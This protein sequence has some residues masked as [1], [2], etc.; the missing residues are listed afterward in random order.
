MGRFNNL[1]DGYENHVLHG[2]STVGD[3]TFTVNARINPDGDVYLW[4]SFPQVGYFNLTREEAIKLAAI[5][6]KRFP[7]DVLGNV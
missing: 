7:L 5:L 3:T 6:N 2:D 1:P 4:S